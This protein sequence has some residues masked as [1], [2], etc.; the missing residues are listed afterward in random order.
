MIAQAASPWDALMR[1]AV[2]RRQPMP[3]DAQD[4]KPPTKTAQLLQI[5]EQL[6]R[7]PTLTLCVEMDMPSVAVW[8]LL[9]LPRK[10]GQ[11]AFDGTHWS[12]ADD[13]VPSKV[14]RAAELL[15]AR[16]WTV[17]DPVVGEPDVRNRTS[18]GG[19]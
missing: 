1:R 7:V 5:I 15:R 18:G 3:I 13:Y 12:L 19:K 4:G 17:I 14:R 9:K 10:V 8:G 6:G 11:V 16:G 2:V